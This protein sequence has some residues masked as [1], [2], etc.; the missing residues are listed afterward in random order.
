MV[1]F[2]DCIL[3]GKRPL[4]TGDDG[5]AVMVIIFAAYASASWGRRVV[6]RFDPE[7]YESHRPMTRGATS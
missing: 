7:H 3:Y 6:Q 1:H 4:I 2:V 5:R